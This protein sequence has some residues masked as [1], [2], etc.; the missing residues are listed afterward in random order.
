MHKSESNLFVKIEEDLNNLLRNEKIKK[1]RS[2]LVDF[3]TERL[4]ERMLERLKEVGFETEADLDYFGSES[5]HQ[6]L[7][8]NREFLEL[9][10]RQMRELERN[11]K[12]NA[13]CGWEYLLEV[14]MKKEKVRFREE[15]GIAPKVWLSFLNQTVLPGE[16]TLEKLRS[17]LSL[18]PEQ[19]Q[20]FDRRVIRYVFWVDDALRKEV[21]DLRERTGRSVSDFLNYAIIGKEAWEVFYPREAE[22][23]REKKTSQDTLLKLVVG[24][25]LDENRAWNFMETAKSTFIVRRDLVVLSCIRCA[26]KDPV[27]VLEVLD[28]FNEAPDGERYYVNPYDRL[29]L[30]KRL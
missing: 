1:L 30:S 24:F 20:E 22:N 2:G 14:Q 19:F 27:E 8:T 12:A 16:A 28:Y 23:F 6:C 4:R 18:T 25:G 7:L 5:F 13:V 17:H 11:W 10:Q 15:A 21:H 26:C 9:S 3:V 29:L